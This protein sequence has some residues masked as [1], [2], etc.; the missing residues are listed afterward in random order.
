MTKREA[1][2]WAHGQAAAYL[3]S[4]KE[5]ML[6]DYASE[7]EATQ[8]LRTEAMRYIIARLRA[9]SGETPNDH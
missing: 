2:R 6:E 8:L 1:R 4:D 7:D 3:E 9:Q 5:Y